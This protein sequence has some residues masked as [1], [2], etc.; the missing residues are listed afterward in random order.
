MNKNDPISFLNKSNLKDGKRDDWG[1][2]R[3]V[4][5]ETEKCSRI[6]GVVLGVLMGLPNNDMIASSTR[7]WLSLPHSLIKAA[8]SVPP[9]H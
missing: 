6:S 1:N 9:S 3:K 4:P 7:C 5:C 8:N 2:V